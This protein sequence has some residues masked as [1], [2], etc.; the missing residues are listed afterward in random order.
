MTTILFSLSLAS[1]AEIYFVNAPAGE[2]ASYDT[3]SGTYAQ[4]GALGAPFDFGSM[5][6][7]PNTATMYM[8][9][10]RAGAGLY[11]VDLSTGAASLV[12]FHNQVDTFALA[13][14][15]TTNTLF[16]GTSYG[17]LFILDTATGAATSVGFYPNDFSGAF[18]SSADG[19]FIH[20]PVGGGSFHLVDP[21]N[22]TQTQLATTGF[23]NDNG[24]AYDPAS[25]LIWSFDWSGYV[26][27]YDRGAGYA[28]SIITQLPF[29]ADGAETASGGAGPTFTLRGT[30]GT[31]PAADVLQIRGATPNGGLAMFIGTNGTTTFGPNTPCPGLVIPVRNASLA[32]SG[33]A[34][35]QGRASLNV[36]VP[37]NA[38][39]VGRAVAVDRA[40]CTVSTVFRPR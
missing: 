38:C 34:D 16:A 35:A 17:E 39:N 36:Q 32:R 25:D 4:I 40:T 8:V 10:G 37:P 31:C 3:G 7:D 28:E 15:P 26:R 20:N 22:N 13:F 9:P 6:W 29:A 33:V 11:T 27:T 23:V 14:D 21:W 1:A 24:L 12:G 19:G 18:W 30:A 5:A 2:L